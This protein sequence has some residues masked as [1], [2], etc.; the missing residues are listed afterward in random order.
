[1]QLETVLIITAIYFSS[2][3]PLLRRV[4]RGID[5][6]FH[7]LAASRFSKGRPPKVLGK[8]VL[9]DSYTYPSL[10][11]FLLSLAPERLRPKMLFM[12]G[13]VSDYGI[14][15]LTYA[16]ALQYMPEAYALAAAVL[17]SFTPIA[18]V[19]S[20]SESPRSLGALWC[21]LSIV[22]LPQR[23]MLEIAIAAVTVA[24]TLLS[25]KMATQTLLLTCLIMSPFL[26]SMNIFF[27]LT[28]LFGFTLALLLTR[29]RYMATL[30]DHALGINF[31]LRH[32]SWDKGRKR[33]DSPKRL[34]KFQPFFYVP[35]AGLLLCPQTFLGETLPI[36]VWSI[37]V[38]VIYCV[39]LWGDGYR[40]FLYSAA[41]TAVLS[42]QL[43]Y[44]LMN[45]LL[46]VPA[47]F[48]S[49][50]VIGR[51]ILNFFRKPVL[52]DF[53]KIVVPDDAVTLV[54]P[55]SITYVSARHLNGKILI[56]G[57]GNIEGLSFE[58]ETLPEMIKNAPDQL[59]EK[60][61][62]T[63]ML[64]GPKEQD[65]IKPFTKRFEKTLETNGYTFYRR[66]K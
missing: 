5:A 2:R 22:L 13:V 33:P 16:L 26:I 31:Y 56:G 20:V 40:Y 52:P 37:T 41:P 14:A 46:I 64:I 38:L 8:F 12:L 21:C 59:I 49:V 10:L 61:N 27:P 66:V 18:Y 23:G 47:L 63:H 6:N 28:L 19:E 48:I 55:S 60:Y 1:M 53:T 4:P 29:G 7:L 51:S 11:H 58:L 30:K 45:P 3:L 39:W 34:V 62:I 32:G 44:T 24:L 54:M 17:Y 25:H 15:L 35:I 42:I 57:G 65:L 36:L 9:G 50:P 43:T